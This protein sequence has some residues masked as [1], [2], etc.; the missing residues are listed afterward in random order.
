MTSH[1]RTELREA[2]GVLARAAIRCGFRPGEARPLAV[3]QEPARPVS[4]LPRAA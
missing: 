1:T 2:A 4:E 3:A